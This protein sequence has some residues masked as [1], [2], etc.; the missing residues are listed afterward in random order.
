M[1]L[2]FFVSL[3]L[4]LNILSMCQIVNFEF[5]GWVLL[6]QNRRKFTIDYRI[7]S[8]AHNRLYH[9]LLQL[10]FFKSYVLLSIYTL[11]TLNYKT[12][13]IYFYSVTHL[14]R[15]RPVQKSY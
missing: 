9:R 12:I 2:L 3:V 14:F 7:E 11:C 8:A 5:T 4:F 10:K 15:V 13:H 6:L 1:F